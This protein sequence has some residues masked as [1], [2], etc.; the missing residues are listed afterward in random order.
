VE[1][2]PADG[3]VSMHESSIQQVTVQEQDEELKKKIVLYYH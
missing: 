3:D 2:K 1:G